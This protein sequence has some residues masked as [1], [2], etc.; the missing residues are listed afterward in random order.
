M[1]LQLCDT[2]TDKGVKDV[3]ARIE[4]CSAP[5]PCR[6]TGMFVKLALDGYLDR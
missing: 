3:W 1:Y 6:G 4:E 5:R 2:V